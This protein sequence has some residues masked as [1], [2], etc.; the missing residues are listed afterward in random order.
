VIRIGDKRS[1]YTLLVRSL[2]GKKD[3][4]K[5][6]DVYE[7]IILKCIFKQWDGQTWTALI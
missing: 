1:S 5:D 4:L 3:H 7:R 6:L 2:E